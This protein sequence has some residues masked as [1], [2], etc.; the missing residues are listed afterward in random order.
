ML[1][2]CVLY[3]PKFVHFLN[4]VQSI[5]YIVC[6][7]NLQVQLLSSFFFFFIKKKKVHLHLIKM[8]FWIFMNKVLEL[9]EKVKNTATLLI[10]SQTFHASLLLLVVDDVVWIP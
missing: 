8:Y 6:S 5:L 4:H 10:F 2:M 3:L 9:F 1:Y 7:L